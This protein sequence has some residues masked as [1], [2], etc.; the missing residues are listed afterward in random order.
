MSSIAD[1]VRQRGAHPARTVV[2]LPYA[3][4]LP[5][6]RRLWAA[7][8]G[9]G[10][11]PRFETSRSWAGA[12]A[13]Q[14][15]AQDLH[16]DMGRDLLTARDWLEQAGLGSQAEL[17]APRLVEAAWQLA[18]L[19]A[20]QPPAQRAAWAADAAPALSEGASPLL[21][22]EGALA[23]IALEWVA[24]SGHATDP[25]LEGAL[26]E[27][28]D[29]LVVLEGLQDEPVV[30]RLARDLGERAVRLPLPPPQPPGQLAL[31]ECADPADE[32]ERA[33]ACVLRH[34]E[35]GR[36]PVA[37]GAIDRVLARRVRAL[38]AARGVAIR[39]ESGW[40]LS[41][42]RAGAHVMGALRACA[43]NAASDTV[44]DWLKNTPECPPLRV[45]ALERLLRRE[46]V[47]DWSAVAHAVG[48]EGPAA[49]LVA[50][51]DGWRE[52]MQRPRSLVQW[53]ESLA[54]LLRACGRMQRLES[55]AAGLRLLD[56]LGLDEAGQAQWQALPQA[57]RRL[58]LA[59]FTAWVDQILEAATF[60]PAQ[61]PQEQVV[62][63]PL[64]QLLGR[65]V[66]AVVLAGCDEER[67]APSPPP[68]GDW[69]AAQ[70]TALGLP[71]R[72][73]L[74]AQ[75]RAGWLYALQAPH[76]DL[77]WRRADEG[78]EPVLPSPLVQLLRLERGL[79]LAPDPRGALLLQS[80]P[81]AR[82]LPEGRA[83][84]LETLSASSY[85]DLRRC[86][87]RFFALR[88]L[89]LQEAD[90]IDADLDKRDFGNWLHGVLR[91]FHEALREEPADTDR[92]A[93]LDRMAQEGT[94]SK[95][96]DEGE[97]LP[98]LAAWPQVREGYLAWLREHEL[99]ERAVFD[100]AEAEHE[101]GLGPVRLVGR[102]DRIDRLPDGRVLVIDYKTEARAT[103]Q[104]RI[105]RPGEDTQLAFYAALLDQDT[106]RAAYVNVSE[107]GETAMLEQAAVVEARGLL[108][109][110]I[111][112]DLQR[113]AQGT[114]LPALGEGMVCDYCAARGLCRKD[115]W[116]E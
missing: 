92:A 74:D 38:L 43:W 109:E 7:Q 57:G 96:L 61:P 31:H 64:H 40:K 22:L 106:L 28:L 110:G 55:D 81:V 2:L 90:E 41:T 84:P 70:R 95:G 98:F 44:V 94:R 23:R 111:L 36:V 56:A 114:P 9:D 60:Q 102:I 19:A 39:D 4:L 46:G 80:Q 24:A 14:A 54:G 48:S 6:A 29:L 11:A 85:E 27:G 101:I 73:L 112:H 42:T 87:Y 105:R 47:R 82:P 49:A 79:A 88:Q 77:L 35:A 76:I 75:L 59:E 12:M 20:A 1:L 13:A 17:L 8:A 103:T 115:F 45:S 26:A 30:Q 25:L 37:L 83:L 51:A 116:K 100:E 97:F 66:A 91:G 34:I 33:A 65:E 67:L 104:D 107:R 21:A 108:A 93:L 15:S 72:E 78:G 32:A 50:Q 18:P 58:G 113:I 10:F 71:A 99:G 16:L 63:L 69:T 62:I 86:P 3:Q 53:L 5:V 89:G 52:A 68:P